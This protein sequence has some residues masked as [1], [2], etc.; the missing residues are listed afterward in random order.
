M[1]NITEVNTDTIHG[2]VSI[3]DQYAKVNERRSACCA[4]VASGWHPVACPVSIS[5]GLLVSDSPAATE[6][7]S[8]VARIDGNRI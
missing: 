4:R 8:F 5:C 1:S 3:L 2:A 7:V 6:N